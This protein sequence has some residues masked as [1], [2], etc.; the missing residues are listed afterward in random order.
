LPRAEVDGQGAP[1][2]VGSLHPE[3]RGHHLA[4]VMRRTA[5]HRPP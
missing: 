4:M 2:A 1:G 5:A 3:H